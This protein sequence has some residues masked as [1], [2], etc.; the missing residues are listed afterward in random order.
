MSTVPKFEEIN[1]PFLHTLENFHIPTNVKYEPPALHRLPPL[2]PPLEP[3]PQEIHSVSNS[4]H[5]NT[6]TVDEVDISQDLKQISITHEW[7]SPVDGITGSKEKTITATIVDKKSGYTLQTS[8]EINRN[9]IPILKTITNDN[10]E[11]TVEILIE[12][13]KVVKHSMYG[14]K[15]A[16]CKL[17]DENGQENKFWTPCIVKLFIP[18]GAK[19]AQPSEEIKMRSDKATVVGIFPL[20]I[21][22][23]KWK[24]KDLNAEVAIHQLDDSPIYVE[25]KFL[26]E[27]FVAK[28]NN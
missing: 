28:V 6:Y 17:L 10:N 25:A 5:P 12:D 20:E 18:Q 13:K 24:A 16:R 9:D 8:I 4:K 21:V 14:Y 22:Y 27:Y 15:A 2:I 7:N 1:Y 23:D 19:V 26:K 3:W 11:L